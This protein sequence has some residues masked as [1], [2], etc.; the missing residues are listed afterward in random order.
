LLHG[1][2]ALRTGYVEAVA[3]RSD[4]RGRG[5]GAAVMTE[6]EGVIRSAYDLGALSSS[7]GAAGFYRSRGWQQ[8]PGTAS[9]LTREGVRRIAEEEGGIYLLPVEVEVELDVAGDLACD[10]RGGD[11]W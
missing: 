5:L 8:W 1:D 11:V 3:V 10:W 4:R 9:V 6:L 2:R 7:G